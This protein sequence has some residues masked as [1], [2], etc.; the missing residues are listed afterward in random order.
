MPTFIFRFISDQ[1]LIRGR[2]IAMFHNI[3]MYIQY[4]I[5]VTAEIQCTTQ[6]QKKTCIQ[7][8]TR[9]QG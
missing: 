2:Y 7:G 8:L 9:L 5:R 3:L 1:M 4:V 6:D